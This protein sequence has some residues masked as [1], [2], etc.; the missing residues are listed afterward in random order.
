MKYLEVYLI[1]YLIKKK[2][3]QEETFQKYLNH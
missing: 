2:K 1:V 3:F